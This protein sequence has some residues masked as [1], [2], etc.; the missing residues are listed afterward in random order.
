LDNYTIE[1]YLQLVTQK[2]GGDI[3]T[4]RIENTMSQVASIHNIT[5]S[6]DSTTIDISDAL[7]PTIDS[8]NC[9]IF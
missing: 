9:K 6:D 4:D 3:E 1:K 2:I 7:M 8:L 5:S